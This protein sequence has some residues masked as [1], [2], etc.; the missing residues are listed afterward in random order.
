MTSR[1]ILRLARSEEGAGARSTL[2]G[3]CAAATGAGCFG[4]AGRAGI[5]SLVSNQIIPAPIPRAMRKGGA[6]RA[7]GARVARIGN[8]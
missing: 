7:A 2:V 5:S 6:A 3:G 4:V 8:V 1:V